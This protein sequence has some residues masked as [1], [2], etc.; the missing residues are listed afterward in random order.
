MTIINGLDDKY[1]GLSQGEAFVELVSDVKDLLHYI[2][3]QRGETTDEDLIEKVTWRLEA[4]V[5]MVNE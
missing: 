5:G 3:L 4:L 2:S 1:V